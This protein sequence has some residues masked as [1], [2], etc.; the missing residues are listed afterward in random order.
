MEK[1]STKL[2]EGTLPFAT[3][4]ELNTALQSRQISSSELV[5]LFS[6][7]LENIGPQYNAL[8]RS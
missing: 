6:Q 1:P 3:I 5:K 7:Q 2:D 8:A 4:P